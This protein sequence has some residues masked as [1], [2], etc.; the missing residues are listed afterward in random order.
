[1]NRPLQRPFWGIVLCW[2]DLFWPFIL[3]FSEPR[4]EAWMMNVTGWPDWSNFRPFGD[5]LLCAVFRKLQTTFW[6]NFSVVKVMHLFRQ[7][8]VGLHLHSAIFSKTHLVT[9]NVYLLKC[10]ELKSR[11]TRYVCEK[12]AQNVAQSIFLSKLIRKFNWWRK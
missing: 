1:M 7:K 4:I 3:Y 6:G 8:W 12:I 5:C 2:D 10:F 11:V 9:L